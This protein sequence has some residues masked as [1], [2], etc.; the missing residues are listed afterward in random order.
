MIILLP[1]GQ[2]EITEPLE[3]FSADDANLTPKTMELENFM[4]YKVVAF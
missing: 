1:Q 2:S 3:T 4:N